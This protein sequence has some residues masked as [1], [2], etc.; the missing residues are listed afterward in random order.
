MHEILKCKRMISK[1]RENVWNEI[2]LMC[3]VKCKIKWDMDVN[4]M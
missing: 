1:C 2:L 4:K 3:K